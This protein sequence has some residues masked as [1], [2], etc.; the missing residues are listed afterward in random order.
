M[1]PKNLYNFNKTGF[2]IGYLA[3]QIVFTQIDK[4]VY[5]S[6]PDNR[7][8]VTS[9]ESIDSEGGTTDPIIIIPSQIIKENFFQLS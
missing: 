3:G 6:D 7:E 2:R 5:I 8:I 4:Q 1:K 9:I